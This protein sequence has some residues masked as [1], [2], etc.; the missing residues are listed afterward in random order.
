[1]VERETLDIAEVMS[2]SWICYRCQTQTTARMWNSNFLHRISSKSFCFETWN[3]GCNSTEW[4]R[5]S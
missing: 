3:Y 5:K 4:D 2:W 1:M